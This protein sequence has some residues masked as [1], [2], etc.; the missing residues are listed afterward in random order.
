M[1]TSGKSAVDLLMRIKPLIISR[2]EVLEIDAP[3][4][5]SVQTRTIWRYGEAAKQIPVKKYVNQAVRLI[6]SRFREK[7]KHS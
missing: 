1:E 7:L 5:D 6:N 4:L 2:V 3:G